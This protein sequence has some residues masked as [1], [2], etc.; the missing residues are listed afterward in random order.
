MDIVLGVSTT[1]T[2]V[3][4]VLVEGDK[5]D[6]V[7][8]DHDVFD[9]NAADGSATSNAADQVV[10]AVLG[11]QESAATGGHHLKAIGVTWSDHNEGAALRD[12]LAAKGLDDVMLV[13]ASHAAASLAQAAFSS[14]SQ[15]FLYC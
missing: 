13:S 14:G 2:T 10:E 1:P 4:M 11:T 8:V 7:T 6:G 3:R 12:A 5:A 15:T 9:I